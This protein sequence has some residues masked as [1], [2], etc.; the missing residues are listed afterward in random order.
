MDVSEEQSKGLTPVPTPTPPPMLRRLTPY[1]AASHT[2][3]RTPSPGSLGRSRANTVR[4]AA[5]E[6]VV[7]EGR[8]RQLD[9]QLDAARGL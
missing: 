9:G 7:G 1:T 2:P 3:H 8:E 5:P 4:V 6:G